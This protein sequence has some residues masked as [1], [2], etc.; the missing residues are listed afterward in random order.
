MTKSS[1][2]ILYRRSCIHDNI[3]LFNMS[4]AHI[5]KFNCSTFHKVR[6]YWFQ[7]YILQLTQ[8]FGI[9]YLI[10]IGQK[11]FITQ[12]IVSNLNLSIKN[13]RT[14]KLHESLT[15]TFGTGWT[16]QILMKTYWLGRNL[17]VTYFFVFPEIT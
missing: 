14:S 15:K 11:F 17:Y 10:K 3:Y 7:I 16:V 9:I 12:R 5:S 2:V 8:L 4:Y 6:L 1:D 13:T